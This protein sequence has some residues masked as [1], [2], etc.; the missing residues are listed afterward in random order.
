MGS[1]IAEIAAP[2]GLAVTFAESTSEPAALLH[3]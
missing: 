1:G 3:R 2:R